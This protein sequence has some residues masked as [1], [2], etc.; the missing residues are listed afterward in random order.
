M[1]LA[2]ETFFPPSSTGLNWPQSDGHTDKGEIVGHS[3]EST[4]RETNE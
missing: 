4:K 3:E 2:N 1:F